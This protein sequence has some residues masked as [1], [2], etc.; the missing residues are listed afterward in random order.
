M[1]GDAGDRAVPV[2]GQEVRL[3]SDASPQFR[4]RPITLLITSPVLPSTV[5]S[6]QQHDA[7]GSTWWLIKG[8]ELGSDRQPILLPEVF[9]RAGG[10]EILSAPIRTTQP[11]T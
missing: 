3:G 8:W 10:C 7:A 9:V 1:K 6:I 4:E 5:D 2:P 11:S